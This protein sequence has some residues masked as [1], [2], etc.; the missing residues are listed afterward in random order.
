[1]KIFYIVLLGMIEF[2]YTDVISSV[3]YIT[4]TGGIM[5]ATQSFEVGIL[6]EVLEQ[7]ESISSFKAYLLFDFNNLFGSTKTIQ[8]TSLVTEVTNDTKTYSGYLFAQDDSDPEGTSVMVYNRDFPLVKGYKLLIRF[9]GL[10][11]PNSPDVKNMAIYLL[12]DSKSKA[13]IQQRILLPFHPCSFVAA[14][15]EKTS[16]TTRFISSLGYQKNGFIYFIYPKCMNIPEVTPNT[17]CN[18][19]SWLKIEKGIPNTALCYSKD[20]L[21]IITNLNKDQE[22][23]KDVMRFK[24]DLNQAHSCIALNYTSVEIA[25]SFKLKSIE[26]ASL[27]GIENTPFNEANM[28][29]C[30]TLQFQI[31][32]GDSNDESSGF[33]CYSTKAAFIICTLL[34]IFSIW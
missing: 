28:N 13:F 27:S 8:V 9:L 29:G 16:V 11:P 5:K 2:S 7:I 19:L 32:K 31:V 17:Y 30:Q 1:M 33:E 26:S 6:I 22:I 18:S 34:I 24:I 25:D 20:N 21:L 4:P 10:L 23:S 15:T 3:G 12:L 14:N